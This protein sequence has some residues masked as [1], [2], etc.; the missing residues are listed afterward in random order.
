MCVVSMVGDHYRDIW[1]PQFP[2]PF[3]PSLPGLP[4]IPAFPNGPTRQEFD[5]L[6]R[7]VD[8]MVALLKRAKKYDDD[9]GEPDCEIEDK[10]D[11]L[12]K[13]AKLVGVDL[14]KELGR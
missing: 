1:K 6:K 11:F 7:Q 13:V 10:M 14:N 5:Q 8:E 4:S 2:G 3:T 9:N 12:R